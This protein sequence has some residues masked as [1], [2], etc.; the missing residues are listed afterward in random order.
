MDMAEARERAAWDRTTT[1][2]ALQ[3]NQMRDKKS[4]AEP[5][6]PFEFNPLLTQ[7]DIARL[8]RELKEE[9]RK[10]RTMAPITILK[11]LFVKGD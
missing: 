5:Y 4:H 8:R 2:M 9:K 1:L 3:A 7:E 6:Q 10:S 11:D